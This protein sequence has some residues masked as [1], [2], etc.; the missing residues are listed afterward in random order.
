KYDGL[1]Q[2]SGGFG[3]QRAPIVI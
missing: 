3:R 2:E 1:I